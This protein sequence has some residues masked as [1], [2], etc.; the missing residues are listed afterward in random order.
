MTW[1]QYALWGALGGL[2]V[3]ATQFYRAIRRFKAWPWE[4]KGES[5]P[6]V[7]LASVAIR[8]GL[9][10]IAALVMGQSGAISGVLGVF[11]AGVAAPLIFEQMMRQTPHR[12]SADTR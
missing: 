7:L 2:V 3:E 6:P 10:L 8:V 5:A 12:D 11:G 9:G 4:V 1:W